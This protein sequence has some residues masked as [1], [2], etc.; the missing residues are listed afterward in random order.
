MKFNLILILFLVFIL[1]FSLV[2]SDVYVGDTD[3]S[4]N[5]EDGC[6]D[7][8]PPDSTETSCTDGRD[9]D[10]NGYTDCYDFQCKSE[11]SCNI[12]EFTFGSSTIY[13]KRDSNKIISYFKKFSNRVSLNNVDIYD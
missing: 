10:A 12:E 6:G 8:V 3:D 1:S 13:V 4:C 2:L 11:I 7:S 5:E 9:N